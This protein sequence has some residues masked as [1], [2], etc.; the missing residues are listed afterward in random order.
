MLTQNYN[1]NAATIT[2]TIMISLNKTDLFLL[3]LI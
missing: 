1:N 3:C 2:I